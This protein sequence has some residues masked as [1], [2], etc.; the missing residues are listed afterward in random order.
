M[1]VEHDDDDVEEQFKVLAKSE[2]E[3]LC[4][5]RDHRRTRNIDDV[6]REIDRSGKYSE[7]DKGLFRQSLDW[8]TFHC[9]NFEY[10]SVEG[11]LEHGS[12][13]HRACACLRQDLVK[14]VV[15]K[16]CQ[17]EEDAGSAERM[18]NVINSKSLRYRRTPLH[19]A[20][21]HIDAYDCAKALL[22]SEACRLKEEDSDGMTPVHCAVLGDV[23]SGR[24]PGSSMFDLLL[25]YA[26]MH[27]RQMPSVTATDN[28]GR[29]PTDLIIGKGKGESNVD[30]LNAVLSLRPANVAASGQLDV[31]G[32]GVVDVQVSTVRQLLPLINQSGLSHKL[33]GES[34]IQAF[35]S[36]INVGDPSLAY[37]VLSLFFSHA[38]A[39]STH[40]LTSDVLQLAIDQAIGQNCDKTLPLIKLLYRLSNQEN[41]SRI[42]RSTKRKIIAYIAGACTDGGERADLIKLMI[43]KDKSMAEVLDAESLAMALAKSVDEYD[44]DLL[45]DLCIYSSVLH[46]IDSNVIDLV[47]QFA[48]LRKLYPILK[49]Q[50]VVELLEQSKPVG[51]QTIEAQLHFLRTE[52]A[53]LSTLLWKTDASAGHVEMIKIC[54]NRNVVKAS[55]QVCD[56][57]TSKLVHRFYTDFKEICKKTDLLR[58]ASQE[59][60]RKALIGALN[61]DGDMELAS[62]CI[63]AGALHGWTKWPQPS[64]VNAAKEMGHSRLA[65]M[66][67]RALDDQNLLAVGDEGVDSLL[68]RVG[69]PPGA[70]KSTL[71]ESLKTPWLKGAFRWENQPD[72]GDKN[73]R[74]R[75]KGIKVHV[76]KDNDGTPY[77]VLDL[78]GH[79]DFAVAHQLFIGQGEVPIINIIVISSQYERIEMQKEIM[80]WCA[81]Y[82][83][84]YRPKLTT[85]RREMYDDSA[86]Q[87]RQPVI[88]IATR[89]Q[90]AD[91][92]N[93]R[94]VIDCFGRAKEL[95]KEFL[96]FQDG[97]VFVDARKSWAAATRALREIL[98][99]VKADLFK[100]GFRQPA[101]CSDIQRALPQIRTTVG[102]PL[103]LRHEL[104]KHVAFAL[105]TKNHTFS[106]HVIKSLEPVLD[107]VLR[108]MSDAAEI[109]SF[110]KP[111]LAKYL[112]IKPQWLLSHV[113]GILMSPENFPPPHVVYHHGRAKRS[114]AEAAVN[115]THV[116]GKDTLEMVAQLGLCILEDEDMIVPSKLDTE[117]DITTW[118]ARADVDIY[119]GIRFRCER[120][121]MSPALFPQLQVHIYN[122]FLELCGQVSKLWKDGIHVTLHYSNAEGLLEAQRDQMAINVL[123]RGSSKLVRDAYQLLQLLKEQVLFLA[124]EFSPGSDMA[125]KILSSKELRT[126]AEK[127]SIAAPSACYEIDDV[128]NALERAHPLIRPRDGVGEPEDPFSLISALP[129]THVHFMAP[130]TRAHY[131]RIMNGRETDGRR[132]CLYM[133][134]KLVQHLNP[135]D[136]S[137]EKFNA[138]P[139]PTDEFLASWSR[140][141]VNNT[142][143][144]L[145]AFATVM[146]HSAA[147]AILE[148][149]LCQM[150]KA[151]TADAGKVAAHPSRME[152]TKGVNQ[153][154]SALLETTMMGIAKCFENSFECQELAIHLELS[155]ESGF[156]IELQDANPRITPR[157][158]A[159]RVMRQWVR[160]KGS[161]ATGQKLYNVLKDDMLMVF[162]AREV[163]TRAAAVI[164]SRTL[165]NSSANTWPRSSCLY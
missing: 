44:T 163:P 72:E 78:G 129:P 110:Q 144:R 27:E 84:R 117:R 66:L 71:V 33:H 4:T 104:Y 151:I 142:V 77:H 43:T 115:N 139:N 26:F 97:P 89:L 5:A 34:L 114:L 164:D 143:D 88:V 25:R 122:Q 123:V 149:E 90:E 47:L 130:E 92:N 29:T 128:E 50:Q 10:R 41:I 109:V 62:L 9:Q 83:S 121:P 126:L 63:E 120:V 28:R 103:I 86:E 127:G 152:T 112:V 140:Q 105:S 68:I 42:E 38:R 111:Q 2:L 19:E 141:S 73:Y 55:S 131:C 59:E 158:L 116:P 31:P 87:P 135:L 57:I 108:K 46:L 15:A 79:D 6:L 67:Q 37:D 20:A 21:R 160:E 48:F 93:I 94:N 11:Q 162:V 157:E 82:A 65:R 60:Q 3:Q 45:S 124:E 8:A 35:S 54:T 159:F 76:F 1:E 102:G 32:Q 113:V 58:R 81:F 147:V 12:F 7:K 132:K 18:H 101:L 96:V 64:L 56:E 165:L 70:G 137:S 146:Q 95:Y 40:V 155:K 61:N 150:K 80:K 36:A 148:E 133:W 16:L 91:K 136:M 161:A 118:I 51:E 99:K 145:L 23:A 13:L 30:Y 69:G 153:K 74:T 119:F 49:C 14:A 53:S 85:K 39:W 17:A 138:S 156:V 22:A 154:A 106:K 75:T 134:P 24:T 100:K 107:A 125:V 98:A 52:L